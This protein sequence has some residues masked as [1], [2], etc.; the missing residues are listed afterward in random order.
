MK[1]FHY[2]IKCKINTLHHFG[3]EDEKWFCT[4]CN[5][6]YDGRRIPKNKQKVVTN[7]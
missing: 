5:N 2:C 4:D 6:K 3:I 1:S 7:E